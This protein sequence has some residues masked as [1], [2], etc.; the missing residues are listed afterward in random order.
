VCSLTHIR[1]VHYAG[2]TVLRGLLDSLV[3]SLRKAL[4]R[5]THREAPAGSSWQLS[6]AS[7]VVLMSEIIFGAS[8]AWLPAIHSTA[9]PSSPERP[10]PET[11]ACGAAR[12]T[13]SGPEQTGDKSRSGQPL[14]ELKAVVLMVEEEWVRESLWGLPTSAETAPNLAPQVRSWKW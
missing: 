12:V 10:A 3:G 7:T 1:I 9:V 4:P 8:S 14:E 2:G 11:S 5:A 6:A 13:L